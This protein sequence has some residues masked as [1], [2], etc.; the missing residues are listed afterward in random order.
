MLKQTSKQTFYISVVV[1]DTNE[2]AGIYGI[3]IFVYLLTNDAFLVVVLMIVTGILVNGPFSL[4]TT[5]VS[6]NLVSSHVLYLR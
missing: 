6:A 1:H 3:P 4:I 5:A 2:Y